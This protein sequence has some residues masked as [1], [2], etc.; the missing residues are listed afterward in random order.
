MKIIKSMELYEIK[1][2]YEYFNKRNKVYYDLLSLE[3][4]GENPLKY[5]KKNKILSTLH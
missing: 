1:K 2:Y 5:N 3:V 4:I